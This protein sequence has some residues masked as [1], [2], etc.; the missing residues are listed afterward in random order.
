MVTGDHPSTAAAIAREIGL[1]ADVPRVLEGKDLPED[2]EVLGAL[3]DY[4]GVVIARVD[5]E[6]KVAIAHALR[7]RGHVVAMTG[8]GVNDGPALHEA[9]IGIAMGAGGTDVA[10]ETADLVLLDDDFATIVAAVEQGRATFANIRR[11]MTYHLSANVAELTPFLVWALSGGRFPLA[12]SVLQILAIDLG[13]DILPAVALGADPPSPRTLERPPARGHL[14]D[15]TVARRAF[16]V[17]G[18]S[19]AVV[20]MAAFV[21]TF[22]G[23]GWRPG[24]PFPGGVVLQSASGAAWAAVVLGQVAN[25]FA[26]RSRSQPAWRVPVRTNPLIPVAVSVEIAILVALIWIGPAASLLGHAPPTSAGWVVALSAPAVLIIADAFD[27]WLRTVRRS[28]RS[29]VGGVKSPATR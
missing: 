3:V 8:D 12:L 2:V 18:P 14:L 26:C 6:Q 22:V 5:P 17:L 19:E 15:R 27:K 20:A 1:I 9:D 23:A 29:G 21:L 24:A 13:T 16:C 28:R 10:R 11:F 25:T 4:D 7:M